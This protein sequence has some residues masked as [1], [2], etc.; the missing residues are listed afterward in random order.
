MTV[1]GNSMFPFIQNGDVITLSPWGKQS[2]QIG[3]IVAYEQA[4][5]EKLIIH[6]LIQENQEWYILRGDNCS[7][8]DEV[9]PRSHLLGILTQIK[10]KDKTKSVRLGKTKNL[11][12]WLSRNNILSLMQFFFHIPTRLKNLVQRLI[13]K[14]SSNLLI[15]NLGRDDDKKY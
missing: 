8:P 3:D 15:S 9:V 5:A 12:T 4:G 6:R 7:Q 10:R 2:P 13:P 11:I 1:Y 14:C